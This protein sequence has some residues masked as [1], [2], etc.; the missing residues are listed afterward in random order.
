MS[1]GEMAAYIGRPSA[2]RAV[3]SANGVNPIAIVVPCHR[4]IGADTTLTGYAS[5]L[6]RKGWLLKHEGFEGFIARSQNEAM[7]H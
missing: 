5:G 6:S 2:A 3:G 1:Y 4:L 7:R